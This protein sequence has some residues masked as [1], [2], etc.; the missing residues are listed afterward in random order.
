MVLIDCL[1][2]FSKNTLDYGSVCHCYDAVH[3]F[4]LKLV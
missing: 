3:R 4:F 1:F 2:N